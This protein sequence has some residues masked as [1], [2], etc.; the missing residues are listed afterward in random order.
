MSEW[1]ASTTTAETR[2]ETKT[3]K[4]KSTSTNGKDLTQAGPVKGI[5]EGGDGV[6]TATETL[7]GGPYGP[8]PQIT[9]SV[10]AE[11][12]TVTPV[13]DTPGK[14]VVSVPLGEQ[15]A[16]VTVTASAADPN[17]NPITESMTVPVLPRVY[18]IDLEQIT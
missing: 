14:A 18:A 13:L 5:I 2:P 7:N 1:S 17:G 9:W 16:T 4:S 10:D 6:F 12:V 15:A 11:D 3:A 8:Q